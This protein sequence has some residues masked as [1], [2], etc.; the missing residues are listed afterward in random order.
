MN[1]ES[2]LAELIG[3]PPGGCTPRARATIRSRPISGSGSGPPSTRS[4]AALAQYQQALAEK[5]LAHAATVMPASPTCRPR[6]P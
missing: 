2:R 1:V 5:A 6:S 4:S 3:R